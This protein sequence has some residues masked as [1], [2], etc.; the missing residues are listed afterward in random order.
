MKKIITFL[1]TCILVLGLTACS[2]SASS[3]AS[4]L[5]TEQ[6]S[7][8]STTTTIVQASD[9]NADTS[10]IEY[11]SESVALTADVLAEN[12]STH[13]AD[14]DYTY[15]PD[16][17]IPITLNGDSI[18]TDGSGVIVDGSLVTIISAGT[19]SLS[20]SLSDGQIIV[21]TTDEDPVRLILNSVDLYSS[22]SAPIYIKNAEKAIILLA[23]GSVNTLT[24]SESYP[25]ST[26]STARLSETL[27]VSPVTGYAHDVAG[28]CPKRS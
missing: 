22:T 21:D 12:S 15:D 25:R 4:T 2:T 9:T 7:V 11:A 17:V 20:D 23:D 8:Q 16:S 24:D 19:Y 5:R 14:A 27:F 10:T 28:N 26:P 1:L 13:A 6:S 18:T 3:V